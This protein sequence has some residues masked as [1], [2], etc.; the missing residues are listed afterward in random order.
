MK[1]ILL[2]IVLVLCVAVPGFTADCY[3]RPKGNTGSVY[4]NANGNSY[5]NAFSAVNA[6]IS[7]TVSSVD[8]DNDILV[9]SGTPDFA[10]NVPV[11][12]TSTGMLPEPISAGTV[13]WIRNRVS[14]SNLKIASE[15]YGTVI[16]LTSTGSGTI[17][18]WGAHGIRWSSI[19]AGD[20]IWICDDFADT[21]TN[22]NLAGYNTLTIY[23]SGSEGLPVVIRAD[24]DNLTDPPPDA[25]ARENPG[26][27]WSLS[28][29]IASGW[30]AS[31]PSPVFTGTGLNDATSQGEPNTITGAVYTVEI[32]GTGSPD[33]F[34]WKKDS[35]SYT[36][37][38]AITGANQTLADAVA[39][40][41]TAT[42]GHT[43]GDIWTI[44][45]GANGTYQ[46]NLSVGNHRVYYEDKAVINRVSVFEGST[47][48][49]LTQLN[50]F[51]AG[52]T[53][54]Y[55]AVMYIK[56]MTGSSNP[57]DHVYLCSQNINTAINTNGYDYID[58]KNIDIKAGSISIAAGS[59]NINIDNCSVSLAR[60]GV[61]ITAFDTIVV[62]N[63]AMDYCAD[64][65]YTLI[66]G[67]VSNNCTIE[68]NSISNCDRVGYVGSVSNDGH[69]IG[70]QGGWNNIVRYNIIEN[71]ATGPLIYSSYTGDCSMEAYGNYVISTNDC[72]STGYGVEAMLGVN[73]SGKWIISIY[74]NIITNTYGHG[75]EVN[76]PRTSW[77]TSEPAKIYNNDIYNAG[78]SSIRI[79]GFQN[80][81][82]WAEVKNN[83]CHTMTNYFV[84]AQGSSSLVANW[85]L[86]INNNC[87][88]PG[89]D[90]GDK[91]LFQ[92]SSSNDAKTFAEWKELTFTPDANSITL[93]PLLVGTGGGVTD[94]KLQSGSPCIDAGDAS[95]NTTVTQDYFGKPRPTGK[96]SI[97]AAEYWIT[98]GNSPWSN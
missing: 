68:H 77:N 84:K 90:T 79:C 34:K 42:T 98:G 43:S 27:F 7:D 89:A 54:Y 78:D 87:Y 58:I 76:T 93:D 75:I 3:V 61:N 37:G 47:R 15:Q 85:N 72:A 41:F 73:H 80:Y 38:V 48:P 94:F 67:G 65:I 35:G 14:A 69:S 60:Y 16:N 29:R 53:G 33:T 23:K 22:A 86:D 8:V 25:T 4:G 46:K 62:S 88:Y 6:A 40:K 52:D 19:S 96:N 17:T 10:N 71:C 91:F 51:S 26:V 11:M 45:T 44:T 1:K 18:I 32:D 30:V 97:G 50:S 63:C 74:N 70:L 39:I 95:V 56:A 9:V 31:L 81:E 21:A 59:N 24:T 55:S 12:F 36:T 92:D 28:A 20:T 82:V 57:N 49:T 83:I 66:T 13:Y 2:A 64:G 5:I